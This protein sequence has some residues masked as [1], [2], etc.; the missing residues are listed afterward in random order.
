MEYQTTTSAWKMFLCI[1]DLYVGARGGLR[2]TKL[3]LLTTSCLLAHCRVLACRP[4]GDPEHPPVL[5]LA[6]PCPLTSQAHCL[7]LSAPAAEPKVVLEG[8]GLPA[9]MLADMF[10]DHWEQKDLEGERRQVVIEEECLVHQEEGKVI[11]RPAP[12]TEGPS[13]HPAQPGICGQFVRP[14][15]RLDRAAG[16]E[17]DRAWGRGQ[18]SL[19]QGAGTSVS[20]VGPAKLEKMH[21]PPR[22]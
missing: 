9:Q 3:S 17:L 5:A 2:D 11:H 19:G 4:G 14:F 6:C 10:Q 12:G 21:R 13:Q 18:G 20:W 16:C 1:W 7:L 8:G 22:F 15:V